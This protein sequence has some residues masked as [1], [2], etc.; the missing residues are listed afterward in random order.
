MC[1]TLRRSGLA[2]SLRWFNRHFERREPFY[3]AGAGTGRRQPLEGRSL[4]LQGMA[5]VER[6]RTMRM[7]FVVLVACAAFGSSVVPAGASP[8]TFDVALR[9]TQISE[10]V[11]GSALLVSQAGIG[12][13]T[14]VTGSYTFD[15]LATGS[16]GLYSIEQ[17]FTLSIG[18]YT[19]ASPA[20]RIRLLPT[21]SNPTCTQYS[22]AVG[23]DLNARTTT[24]IPGFRAATWSLELSDPSI[25]SF[26]LP[27]VPP[28][29][30]G[31]R[32]SLS[33]WKEPNQIQAVQLDARVE[34]VTLSTPSVPEP[35]FIALLA[36]GLFSSVARAG[37]TRLRRKSGS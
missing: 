17:P 35:G 2:L 8:I 1:D 28:P 22:A 33:L 32:F 18:S 21:C 26:A 4:S 25:Q 31:S 10:G 11:P 14:L 6:M 29:T 12:V 24:N 27:L 23:P 3:V 13:G 16:L 30:A 19:I 37:V 7:C 34:S 36:V 15:S 20:Y 9:I 5:E